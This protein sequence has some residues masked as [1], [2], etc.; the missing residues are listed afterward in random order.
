MILNLRDT[1]LVAFALLVATVA[2]AAGRPD[3]SRAIGHLLNITKSHVVVSGTCTKR[4]AVYAALL[5]D[6]VYKRSRVRWAVQPTGTK[7]SVAVT[8]VLQAD[9]PE[10]G[11]V[12]TTTASQVTVAGGSDRGILYGVGRLIRVLNASYAEGYKVA[13]SAQVQVASGLKIT[14]APASGVRGQ[15]LGYSVR[16]P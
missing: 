6:E 14:S 2:L 13:P 8:L 3:T 11:Y 9:L 1:G 15:Q 5:S 7:E 4:C 12:L 16:N 10:E